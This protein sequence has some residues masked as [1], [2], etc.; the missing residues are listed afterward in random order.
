LLE[1]ERLRGEKDERMEQVLNGFP[2]V[3]EAEHHRKD[4][5]R[6]LLEISSKA[7]DIGGE[8]FVQSFHRDVTER[9]KLQEQLFQSQK[10]ESIGLLAGSIAHD[11]NNILSAILGYTELLLEFSS[12]DATSHERVRVI[13]SSARKATQMISK[14]L[15]FARK[16]N[17]EMQA[18]SL[19]DV[20]QDTLVLLERMLMKRTIDVKMQ[21]DRR[22][23]TISGDSNQ[24]GQ[25]V[26]NLVV[27]AM[28]AMPKGGSITVS[29]SFAQLGKE[30]SHVHPLLNPGKYVIL[31]VAD[32]GT[33]I[34]DEI[35]GRIFDPFFT[36]K[37]VGKGSGLGLFIVH[38][39]IDEHDGCIAVDSEPDKGTSFLIR[40][41]VT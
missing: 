31:K 8:L 14:L 41:P 35:K 19:N 22:I 6:V 15:S 32:T 40:Q 10:M 16:G 9:K 33:G 7:I 34:R 12:L 26:M 23:P 13:E 37:D 4:G 38:E 20:V 2:V 27:N 21:I 29:T 18:V 17:F 24:L 1:V 5:S 11:F 36:T 39:I 28:D 25:I 30:A 3:Y